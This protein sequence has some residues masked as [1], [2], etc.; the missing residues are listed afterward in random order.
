MMNTIYK[1]KAAFQFE[2]VGS[3]GPGKEIRRG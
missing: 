3:Q 2:C 1:L